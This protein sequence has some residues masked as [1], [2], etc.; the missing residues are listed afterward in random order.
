M[1]DFRIKEEDSNKIAIVA[2]GYNRLDS[3]ERLLGSLLNANYSCQDVPL[4]ISIDCSG[5]EGLYKYVDD[6]VWPF[7]S[8]Y[9]NIQKTRLGLKNHI[10]QC[11]D[12]SNHF[13][14]VIILEDDIF[15]SPSFYEYVNSVVDYYQDDERIGG[16]SLYQNEMGTPLLPRVFQ[17]D[18]SDTYLKQ[19]P[20]SWG[21]CWTK[22]QWSSFKQ[23]LESFDDK[24]FAS[25]EM[26]EHIKKWK[27]AWS[28]YYMAYLIQTNRF[29][30]FPYISHTTCFG[31]AGEHSS[32]VSTIGQACLL[33][34]PKKYVFKPFDELVQYDIFGVNNA[35]YSWLNIPRAS[36]HVDWAGTSPNVLRKRYVLST[37]KLKYPIIN[38][39]DLSLRPIELNVKYKLA[40]QGIFLYDTEGRINEY[41]L[42]IPISLAYYYL[43]GFNI[44]LLWRYVF[45]YSYFAIKRKLRKKISSLLRK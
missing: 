42:E 12:L 27:K 30:V 43:R 20:A 29:F 32:M 35:I 45:H 10:Y 24:D 36:L 13:K 25:V 8:K 16:F 26:P 5:D 3:I 18:G 11:G 44:K 19:S 37:Q 1:A 41:I 21:E 31:H 40:G 34:G 15:V 22:R 28:K 6:F 23:W 38:S 9:V 33:D 17:N 2:I 7:G 14:A 4:V 39:F